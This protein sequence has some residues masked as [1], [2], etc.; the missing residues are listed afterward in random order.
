MG[1]TVSANL[2][3]D[4]LS[5]AEKATRGVWR[6]VGK[7]IAAGEHTLAEAAIPFRGTPEDARRNAAH[8]ASA[9]P[10]HVIALIAELNNI[11]REL[12]ELRAELSEAEQRE[13]ELHSQVVKARAV[14]G[15]V[16]MPSS[17]A[18]ET[19]IADLE[20]QISR[21]S[22]EC[23]RLAGQ[24]AAVARARAADAPD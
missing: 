8:M 4:M 12:S 16:T 6:P 2:L 3:Q 20:E 7:T 1:T 23:A 18:A 9:S 11:R 10:D 15:A 13:R 19:T 21:A 17:A 22:P 14:I 5:K 24:L